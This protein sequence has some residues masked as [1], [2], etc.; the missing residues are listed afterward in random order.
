MVLAIMG[1]LSGEVFLVSR[2][3]LFGEGISLKKIF[4]RLPFTPPFSGSPFQSF[5][6]Y[7]RHLRVLVD[8]NQS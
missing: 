1:S 8:S 2:V 6:W 4:Y 7:Q 5:K 3:H